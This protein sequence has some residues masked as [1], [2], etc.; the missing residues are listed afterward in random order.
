M[1]TQ[2]NQGERRPPEPLVPYEAIPEMSMVLNGC[3]ALLHY[4]DSSG[5][6]HE[7]SLDEVREILIHDPD[8]Q[9]NIQSEA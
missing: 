8:S 7:V 4:R 3:K 9:T 1:T 5:Q 6:I 2:D